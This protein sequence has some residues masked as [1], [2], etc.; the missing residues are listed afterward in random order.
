MEQDLIREEVTSIHEIIMNIKEDFLWKYTDVI[1]NYYLLFPQNINLQD[2]N[3]LTALHVALLTS[4][5]DDV[6][7]FLLNQ[8]A[9]T[10]IRNKTGFNSLDLAIVN[11]RSKKI[12]TSICEKH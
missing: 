1:V 5:T 11:K 7:I 10:R 8:G 3:G 2:E 6:I 9:N 4:K 12:I